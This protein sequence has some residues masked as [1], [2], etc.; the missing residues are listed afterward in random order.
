MPQKDDRD[1]RGRACV[2][3]FVRL[4]GWSMAALACGVSLAQATP[5]V[6]IDAA[7]GSV[8]AEQESTRRWYP[9]SLTKLVTA[10]V[11]LTAVRQGRV[12]LDTPLV[13]S[14]RAARMPPSKMGFNPGSEVTLDNALKTLMVKSANDIAITI[15]EGLG[16]SVEGF[17]DQ[18]NAA[19]LKLGMH[20]SH[21]MNPNG[22][23]HDDHY[24]SARDMAIMGRAL[25]RD[26][27]EH[28]D[29]F[30]IGA[31]R[32]GEQVIP[33]HNG[34]LGRYPG[35]DGMK[36]GFT[37]AAGFNVV[38]SA[39]RGGRRVITVVLGYPNAKTRT[40][41]A[42]SLLDAGFTNGAGAT[43]ITALPSTPGGPPN[44]RPQ[45]CGG[46]RQQV[47]EDD[48]AVP[49]A[50]TP[51]EGDH[52]AAF[53][54]NHGLTPPA[55][56]LA[57]IQAQIDAR[58]SFEPISVYVG[59]APGW[60]GPALAARGDAPQPVASPASGKPAK[61]VARPKG[62]PAKGKHAGKKPPAPKGKPAAKPKT[63]AR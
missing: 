19:A 24:S 37:C 55:N 53:F 61:V 5:F 1:I 30:G 59:R 31:L 9:A 16:G 54:A 26:F 13:V 60:T 29:L 25:F 45:I 34:L 48:Y 35:A 6:V 28:A 33:T 47:T 46:H 22:L 36:T 44:M 18:M 58:P 56:G 49:V 15:A 51:P 2:A 43:S 50:R 41:K 52:A 38:A 40:L 4:A 10:Y 14:M 42:A 23:H 62:K 11:A 7:T 21:F 32:L 8:I 3:R 12:S 17:A 39:T 27:P 63:A 20:E 57:V